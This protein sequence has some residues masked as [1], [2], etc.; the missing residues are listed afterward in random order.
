[1]STFASPNS[2]KIIQRVRTLANNAEGIKL[3]HRINP[4]YFVNPSYW[5]GKMSKTPSTFDLLQS[6]YSRATPG[7]PKIVADHIQI[8]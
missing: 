1:M 7:T 3:M 4:F 6:T 8:K 5:V 2:L